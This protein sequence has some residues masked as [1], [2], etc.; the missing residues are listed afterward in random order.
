MGALHRKKGNNLLSEAE[1]LYNG[2]D[3][4]ALSCSMKAADT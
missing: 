2:V 4:G 1:I 3:S